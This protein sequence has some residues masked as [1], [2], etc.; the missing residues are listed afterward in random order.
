MVVGT[1]TKWG[2]QMPCSIARWASSAIVWMVLPRPI[3]SAKMQFMPRSCSVDIQYTPS[4][5]YSLRG[6]L[7]SKEGRMTLSSWSPMYLAWGCLRTSMTTGT[8]EVWD[9]CRLSSE[10]SLYPYSIFV[11]FWDASNCFATRSYSFFILFSRSCFFFSCWST[12]L[13]TLMALPQNSRFTWRRIYSDCFFN[14]FSYSRH[15][16]SFITSSRLQ[17]LCANLAIFRFNFSLSSRSEAKS[18]PASSTCRKKYFH[19]VAAGGS[20]TLGNL[21]PNCV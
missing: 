16:C 8:R 20:S 17:V 5:W 19:L 13:R 21:R 1:M 3:S 15:R 6:N 10:S 4:S 14:F 18:L 7:I 11:I 12:T 9:T 2:P